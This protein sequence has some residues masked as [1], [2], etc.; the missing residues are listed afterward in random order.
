MSQYIVKVENTSGVAG[1]IIS[2]RAFSYTD[3]LNSLNEGQLRITGTGETKRGLFEIGSKVYFYRN[4][5]LEFTG[6]INSL[7]YLDAGGISANLKGYEVWLGKENGDY[8]NSPWNSTA[9]ATIATSIIGESSYFTA[10]TIEAGAD[11][12]LKVEA[13]SSL[14]NAIASLTRSTG[15]DIGIDYTNLE[16]DILDHK[17]SSTSVATLNDRIQ[18]TD[19][20]VRK[21]YPIGNDIRVFGKGDGNNQIKSNS[22]TSG[23]DAAS[24]ATYGTI[25]KEYI[26]SSVISQTQADNLAD[27]LVAK[28]KDPISIYE[29]DVINPNLNVVCGDVITLN[30]KTKDLSNEEV[31]IVG[32][33]K[34][35]RG[36]NEFLT[37]QVANKEYS[38]KGRNIEKYLSELQKENNE[39]QTYMQGTTNILTF[40]EMINANNAAP[41]R[42]KAYF[43][44]SDITD[45]AGNLRVNSFKLDYDV[46]PFRSGV[47][48]ASETDVAPTV[49]GTSAS[50]APGVSGT[51][52]ST[53]PG[54][55]G[56]SSNTTPGV[57]GDSGTFYYYSSVGTDSMSTVACSSGSWTT[58][59][60]VRPGSSYLNQTLL[61]D[62][63]VM[64]SSGGDEDIQVRI[65]NDSVYGY[66]EPGV[67]GSGGTVW[68]TYSDGFRDTSMI[69]VTQIP[70][71]TVT[72]ST[73]DIFIQVRP[74]TGAISLSCYLGIYTAKHSHDDGSYYA[75]SHDHDD[76][77]YYAADHD[78]DDGS[79]SAA[80]H[81]HDDGSYGAASH[82]HSVSI[83]DGISDA[84]SVNATSV[85][86][87]VDFWNGTAWINKHSV[88]TTG[89]TID[90]DV[91]LSDGGTYPDAAGFWR[92]RVLT[93]S[94][95]ADLVQGTIKCK[96]ELDT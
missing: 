58:V 26:D 60:T 81:G 71:G 44:E 22:A 31:R 8:A 82:N 42:V 30:S 40:S 6:L 21:S 56:S 14:Y 33:E 57:S 1:T 41:L 9:S 11:I 43:A 27:K 38:A 47:G 53:Q 25:R 62:F 50:T 24:K 75:N 37:L 61:A 18:I 76:G 84:G 72:S 28:Y 87:Y 96:H 39:N 34:G 88:L 74:Q 45:E 46:D 86:I 2:D 48:S 77:S 94:A 12:D 59:A 15:Q 89:K 13:S 5:T 78:H 19:L 83:G 95:D 66:I 54:V 80:S 16:V 3:N 90:Y 73:H 36:D 55:S 92:A 7:S 68:G 79:Y 52:A 63:T 64:G 49:S 70:V 91:D 32:I 69:K 4:G 17:G 51:S 10:G 85:N 20:T 29:F 65:G 67:V 23:Q 35:V 93:D